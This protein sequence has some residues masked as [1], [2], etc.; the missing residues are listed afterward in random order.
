MSFG[1]THDEAEAPILQPPDVKSGL[2]GKDPAAGKDWRQEEKGATEWNVGLGV[3][4]D[5]LSSPHEETVRDREAWCAVVRGD[6]KE[7]DMS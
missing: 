6:S 4:T 7:S 1:R 2:I 3:I 5:K